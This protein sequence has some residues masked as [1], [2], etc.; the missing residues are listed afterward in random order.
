[1][2]EN[3][4]ALSD[5]LLQLNKT[6]KMSLVVICSFF[7]KPLFCAANN[8]QS[9]HMVLSCWLLYCNVQSMGN[10]NLYWSFQF[11]CCCHSRRKNFRLAFISTFCNKRSFNLESSSNLLCSIKSISL[12]LLYSSLLLC[13][14]TLLSTLYDLNYHLKNKITEVSSFSTSGNWKNNILG[15]RS[16][17]LSV[18]SE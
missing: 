15:F 4:T 16:D 1:M 9:V 17:G 3:P 8:C 13:V 10:W 2:A 12:L 14:P 18:F 5:E 11:V 7:A 6:G